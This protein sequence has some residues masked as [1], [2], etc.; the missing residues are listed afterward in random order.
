MK[1]SLNHIALQYT[2]RSDAE[3]FFSDILGIEKIRSFNLT[4]VF[5]EEIFEIKLRSVPQQTKFPSSSSSSHS[6]KA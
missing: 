4:D 1:T 6:S 2:N 3:I 5:S